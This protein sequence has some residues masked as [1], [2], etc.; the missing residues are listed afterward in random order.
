M[1]SLP[2]AW[3]CSP[4]VKTKTRR[5]TTWL[6]R[7]PSSRLI[8]TIF[9]RCCRAIRPRSTLR[10]RRSSNWKLSSRTTTSRCLTWGRKARWLS[11]SCNRKTRSWKGRKGS[12]GRIRKGTTRCGRR[13]L[14]LWKMLW[15]KKGKVY[16][17]ISNKSEIHPEMIVLKNM[18]FFYKFISQK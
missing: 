12:L 13:D 18:T 17:T 8:T 11:G 14:T 1:S 16:M 2:K 5:F 7:T 4:R 6:F 3:L 10:A 15:F 9:F